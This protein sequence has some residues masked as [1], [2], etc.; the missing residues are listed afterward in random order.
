[1]EEPTTEAVVP[2][3]STEPKPQI[4]FDPRKYA[5]RSCKS[6]R[7]GGIIQKHRKN[8]ATGKVEPS[9]NNIALIPCGC[10]TK[11]FLAENPQPSQNVQ[12]VGIGPVKDLEAVQTVVPDETST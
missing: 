8:P 11:R 4:L 10:T 12:M 5:K 9:A 7:G 3:E 6:C 1:M 2:T